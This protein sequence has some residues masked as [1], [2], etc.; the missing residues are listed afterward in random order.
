[1]STNAQHRAL[2]HTLLVDPLG[3][4]AAE[5]SSKH[6]RG[7]RN[8]SENDSPNCSPVFQRPSPTEQREGATI[9]AAWGA[10]SPPFAPQGAVNRGGG[11]ARAPAWR[12]HLP[13][14]LALPTS[15]S[16]DDDISASP[17]ALSPPLHA[18]KRVI[19]LV[20]R[21]LYL[22]NDLAARSRELLQAHGV[23]HVVNCGRNAEHFNG[24][25]NAPQ[26][27]TLGLRDDVFFDSDELH[28]QFRRAVHF[29]NAALAEP[30]AVVF[31]HCREGISRSCGVTLAYL[32]AAEHC[33][34]TQAM[35]GL[36]SVHPRCDP[37]LGILTALQSWTHR[38]DDS[39]PEAMVCE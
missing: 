21:R 6:Y 33:S 16:P 12:Q 27:L 7:R 11:A 19:T 24:Q 2:Q 38:L 25:E 22:G 36:R 9:A 37:N 31:V 15:P 28:E 23:T 4:K 17:A 18:P 39:G 29:I 14:P 35:E 32:M 10:G 26:Y 8:S 34:L 13:S 3:S 30:S 1:M 20:R 5:E